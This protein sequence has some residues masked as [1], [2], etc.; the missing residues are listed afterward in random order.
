MKNV[1][2]NYNE[3]KD[4]IVNDPIYIKTVFFSGIKF[5]QDELMAYII[6]QLVSVQ[7]KVICLNFVMRFEDEEEYLRYFDAYCDKEP[8]G[9]AK[10]LKLPTLLQVSCFYKYKNTRA[11]DTFIL[12]AKYD[13]VYKLEFNKASYLYTMAMFESLR[14]F[15][16]KDY[17][18]PYY[19]CN[20]PD[21]IKTIKIHSNYTP[22]IK[23][24]SLRK[25][26]KMFDWFYYGSYI[27][28]FIDY[29][30]NNIIRLT[31]SL[32]EDKNLKKNI[33]MSKISSEKEFDHIKDNFHND[34]R[35]NP[36]GDYNMLYTVNTE[37]SISANTPMSNYTIIVKSNIKDNIE[38]A[39]LDISADMWGS[40]Q[41]QVYNFI[42]K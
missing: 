33:D 28:D 39:Y 22:I 5:V 10:S 26:G 13:T 23:A 2:F 41:E 3:Y 25:I 34:K 11:E 42:E 12:Y 29:R 6:F 15:W 17:N 31:S 32:A 38:V 7:N 21:N 35:F 19:I 14:S 16:C 30:T 9:V 27:V 20:F 40:I 1:L 8:I 37:Y 4:D 24:V 18:G 36:L